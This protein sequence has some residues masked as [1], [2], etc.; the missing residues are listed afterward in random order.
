[1]MMNDGLEM[2]GEKQIGFDEEEGELI[3]DNCC[4]YLDVD[5]RLKLREQQN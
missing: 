4:H 3:F 2:K 1:M 5:K